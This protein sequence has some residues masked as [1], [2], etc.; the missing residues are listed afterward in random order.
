MKVFLLLSLFTWQ[1]LALFVFGRCETIGD[2]LDTEEQASGRRSWAKKCLEGQ[3]GQIELFSLI[4][5]DKKGRAGYPS[6]A[7]INKDG[8]VS[9][10]LKYFAPTDPEAPC[11]IP[12][13]YT[14]VHACMIGC[15]TPEQQVLFDFGYYPIGLANERNLPFVY[16][17][18]ANTTLE[19]PYFIKSSVAYYLTDIVPGIHDILEI[20]MSSGGSLSVTPNH[21]LVDGQGYMRSANSLNIGDN[22]VTEYGKLDKIISITPGQ[23]YG[24]VYNLEVNNPNPAEKIIVAQGYLNGTTY[25][26]NEGLKNLNRIILRSNLIHEELVK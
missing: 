16:T 5:H 14:I 18:A 26:Q 9:N 11:N 2:S 4:E 19:H 17:V 24:K 12:N 22:L 6:F 20:V 10:P 1:A 25:Y 7:I 3:T 8:T 23:Y 13:G 15:Y 21:P